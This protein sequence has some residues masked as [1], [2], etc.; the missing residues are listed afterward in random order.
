MWIC[1]FQNSNIPID[2]CS[3][4]SDKEF[5]GQRLLPDFGENFSSQKFTLI[6]K[7]I[8]KSIREDRFWV[9]YFLKI[10]VTEI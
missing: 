8:I 1:S 6:I 7:L 9:Q 2:S 3:P 10:S 4:F 5:Q